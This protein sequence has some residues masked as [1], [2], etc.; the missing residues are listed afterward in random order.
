MVT[1]ENIID[2]Q[3][4][5]RISHSLSESSRLELRLVLNPTPEDILKVVS[6]SQTS[7]PDRPTDPIVDSGIAVYVITKGE[8]TLD[9][10]LG[11]NKK[12]ALDESKDRLEQRYSEAN[13]EEKEQALTQYRTFM[14]DVY[15]KRKRGEDL[16]TWHQRALS[17]I[18]KE[19][20][21]A[22]LSHNIEK[23]YQQRKK[24]AITFKKRKARSNLVSKMGLERYVKRLSTKT[25]QETARKLIKS[26]SGIG[27]LKKQEMLEVLDKYNEVVEKREM[28][29]YD[30]IQN[31]LKSDG[32]LLERM[33]YLSAQSGI[34]DRG[35]TESL[36]QSFGDLE[37]LSCYNSKYDYEMG[38]LARVHNGKDNS[39]EIEKLVELLQ[40]FS[41]LNVNQ[42]L[43]ESKEF[44]EKSYNE[45]FLPG[46]ASIDFRRA[47]RGKEDS[48]VS[49]IGLKKFVDFFDG[50]VKR[51]M[52][53][54]SIASDYTNARDF[55]FQEKE[56]LGNPCFRQA[57]EARETNA[58]I[59]RD[60]YKKLYG[61][62][63]NL[64]K[65]QEQLTSFS[66]FLAEET[67][68]P[69]QRNNVIGFYPGSLMHKIRD[70]GTGQGLDAPLYRSVLADKDGFKVAA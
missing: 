57:S 43:A 20:S 6:R 11:E 67:Q 69:T 25:N 28:S 21:L 35:Y 42:T 58:G 50:D 32:R 2:I 64:R 33:V 51:A 9:S 62:S 56:C 60:T 49:K 65:W 12:S 68:E 63:F 38:N 1:I 30:Q 40:G 23:S 13:G 53:L 66:D 8:N 59:I 61:D 55:Y 44:Y 37:T 10:L 52:A 48:L 36:L 7:S 47:V 41:E 39:K 19:D 54:A 15:L 31:K 3:A 26:M 18:N 4:Q 22:C 17:T 29:L 5:G 34:R 14:E 70:H 16:D 27:G 46:R 45:E 24:S